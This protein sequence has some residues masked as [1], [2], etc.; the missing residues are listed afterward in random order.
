M[1]RNLLAI[2]HEALI[3]WNCCLGRHKI[4]R[5]EEKQVVSSV[6]DPSGRKLIRTSTQVIERCMCGCVT[7]IKEHKDEKVR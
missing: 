5:S 6:T 4:A 2:P 3:A 1:F 7:Q